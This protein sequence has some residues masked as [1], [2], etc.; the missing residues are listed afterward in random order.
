MNHQEEEI[1]LKRIL[2]IFARHYWVFLVCV[3]FSLATAYFYNKYAPKKFDV[4]A[5][6]LI[7][8][9]GKSPFSGPQEFMVND[10]F[11]IKKNVYN[12]LLVLQAKPILEKTIQNLDLELTYYEKYDYLYHDIYKKY[13]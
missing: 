7:D 3:L 11:G 1:D 9:D 13:M 12:E 8:E 2:K 10:L 4:V 5:S 6:I